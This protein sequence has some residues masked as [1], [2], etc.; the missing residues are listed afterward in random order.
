[1]NTASEYFAI[2][3][4]LLLQQHQNCSVTKQEGFHKA[5][6]LAAKVPQIEGEP[7]YAIVTL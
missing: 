5:V 4:F 1:M 3:F 6:Q 7:R 2:S